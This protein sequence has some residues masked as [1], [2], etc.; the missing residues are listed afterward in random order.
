MATVA[1]TL[2]GW[3]DV[4]STPHMLASPRTYRPWGLPRSMQAGVDAGPA[5]APLPASLGTSGTF[6]PFGN[7]RSYGDSCL[8][9]EGV[10][11]DCR[12]L[13]RILAF[14]ATKGIVRCEAGVLLCDILDRI[15]PEGWFL[16]VVPGTQF[17]TVGGAIANDV[18]G[19]N[20]HRAGTF[21][22]HVIQ[23]A[24]VRSDGSKR[25][26][27]PT[28]NPDWFAATVAGMG[29][30]GIITWA[31]LQLLRIPGPMMRRTVTRFP[32]LHDFFAL[33]ADADAE[34][35]YTVSWIDSLAAGHALGRGLL[36]AGN[37]SDAAGGRSRASAPRWRMPLTPPAPLLNQISLR[38]FNALNYRLRPDVKRSSVHYRTFFFPLDGID[39]WNRLYGSSGLFQHQSVI[40]HANAEDVVRE[41]LQRAQRA[42][43]GS[44]LT[45]LKTFGQAASPGLLSFPRAGVTLTLDFPHRGKRT[46]RLLDALD[47]V[48]RQAGGAVNP[49]KDARMSAETF[50]ASFPRWRDMLAFKDPRISSDFWRRVTGEA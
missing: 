48:T 46:L 43:L 1:K 26:C 5:H 3:G 11:I 32:S 45:V 6:L 30:T 35:N 40:P 34:H 28:Q 44:F 21:G 17:V 33:S 18:H 14:D 13:D 16:P 47:A 25:I 10:V 29:L 38:V 50:A 41:M 4:L 49:Y 22:R 8:N 24:L 7:G 36:I 19:K 23:F 27:S 37:H 12:P 20:H 31:E 15:V 2:A 9:T 42:G 39:K